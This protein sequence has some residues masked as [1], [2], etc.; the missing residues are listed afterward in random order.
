VLDVEDAFS[1]LIQFLC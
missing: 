1:H